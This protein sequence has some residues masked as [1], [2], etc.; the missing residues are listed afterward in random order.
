MS[1]AEVIPFNPT[2]KICDQCGE[3]RPLGLYKKSERDPDVVARCARCRAPHAIDDPDE[4][5]SRVM[6]YS[7]DFPIPDDWKHRMASGVN[8][9]CEVVLHIDNAEQTDS[10]GTRWRGRWLEVTRLDD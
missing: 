7:L 2:E 9:R 1:L 4:P 3:T 5:P 8:F 10:G 6:S